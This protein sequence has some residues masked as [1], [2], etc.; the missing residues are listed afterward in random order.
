[1]I[2][3]VSLIAIFA[4]TSAAQGWLLTR[5]RWYEIIMLL[6]ITVSMFRPDFVLNRI[7]PEY[8]AFKQDFN[9]QILYEEQR[10]IR[11]HVTRYTDYGERYKLFVIEKNSFDENFSLKDYGISLVD[12]NG[13][14]IIDTLDWKGEA[15]KN[16]LE[17]D[18]II[19]ELKTENFDRPNKD[20]VYVFSLILLIVFGYF[21]YT[22]YRIRKIKTISDIQ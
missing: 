21:N 5:L 13:K 3:I 11:L 14:T 19:T 10:K 12:Q 4:F 22:N 7:Y 8:T 20:V 1:M 2:F 18:D 15:K 6:I 9:E 16:G 17:M